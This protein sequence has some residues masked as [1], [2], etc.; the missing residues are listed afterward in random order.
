[1]NKNLIP[2]A[3]AGYLAMSAAHAA[4]PRTLIPP[5]RYRAPVPVVSRQPAANTIEIVAAPDAAAFNAHI[6]RWRSFDVPGAVNGTQPTGINDR[7]EVT[8]IYYDSNNNQHG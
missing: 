6:A 3:A 5:N 1:M 2:L 8:G 4:D 7:G